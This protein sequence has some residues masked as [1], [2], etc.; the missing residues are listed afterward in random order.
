[1]WTHIT[2]TR[3]SNNYY[4]CRCSYTFQECPWAMKIA[5]IKSP[6]TRT[7]ENI[8]MYPLQIQMY[9]DNK[10]VPPE[11]RSGEGCRPLKPSEKLCVY[12]F[13]LSRSLTAVLRQHLQGTGSRTMSSTRPPKQTGTCVVAQVPCTKWQTAMHT[14]SPPHCGFLVTVWKY[15][16]WLMISCICGSKTRGY[17]GQM[18]I[19]REKNPPV[20]WTRTV[21][22]CVQGSTTY[23]NN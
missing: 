11:H 9:K 7:S 12:N 10:Q 5:Y 17:G 2:I 22:I 23:E 19:Y 13:W 15:C 14:V 1:M 21:Q 4:K 8:C 18:Y 16:W 3:G 6:H 20:T